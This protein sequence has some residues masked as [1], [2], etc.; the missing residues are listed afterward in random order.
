[1]PLNFDMVIRRH[2]GATPFGVLIGLGRQ[3]HQGGTIEGSSLGQPRLAHPIKKMLGI[4]GV[5]SPPSI[6]AVGH[7]S[8]YVTRGIY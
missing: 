7:L 8:L 3:R 2:A 4:F 1:V 6:A 5:R